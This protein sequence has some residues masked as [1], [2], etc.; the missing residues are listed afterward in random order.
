MCHTTRVDDGVRPAHTDGIIVVVILLLT[1]INIIAAATICFFW[2]VGRANLASLFH[3][4]THPHDLP[5]PFAGGSYSRLD[6]HT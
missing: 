5:C 1:I 3:M 2:P 4:H 6:A